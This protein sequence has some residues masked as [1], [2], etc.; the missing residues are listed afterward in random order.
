MRS[1]CGRDEDVLDTWFSSGLWPFSTLGWPEE[2]PELARFYPT[3]VL[4]T[5][6]DII[7][8]WVARMMMLG[9]HLMGEVPFRTSTSTASSATSEGKNVQDQGQHDRPARADRRVRC[10]RAALRAA[11]L[12]RAGRDIK[13]GPSRVEGYRNF[14][15]KLWNAARFA[16]LNDCR[17]DP[18]FD[19]RAAGTRSTAGSSARR[20]DGAQ[21][22]PRRWRPI[23]STMPRSAL[24]HFLWDKFCD[25]YVEL[26]KPL[27]TGEDA[28]AQAETRAT[29]AWALAQALHLLHPLA[30][31]V[32]EELWRELFG[33]PGGML[34][35]SPWPQLDQN[36]VD[37]VAEAELGWL[38]RLV[39]AI[40]A[41]RTELNVPPGAR[42]ALHQQ[43]ARS[44]PGLARAAS[45]SDPAAGAASSAIELEDRLAPP[46]A[47]GGRDRRGHV[48]AAGRRGHRSRR[49]AGE[50]RARGRQAHRRD[51]PRP[52]RSS[53]TRRS[54]RAHPKRWWSSSASGW[55]RAE[56][57]R[58]RLH[59]A[60]HRIG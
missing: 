50:A 26:A 46:K 54:W 53:P 39:G 7:F 37:P 6:F 14:G 12:D 13:F 48:R 31:F 41:A 22:S 24:Y 44:D 33:Q 40:R 42:L 43:G 19:P 20:R 57:T 28:A 16:E 49:R 51:R 1:R 47:L 59:Q 60:L 9:L 3:S 35:R 21:R 30:P 10:R 36:L 29:A 15:T 23:V 11:G 4:V 55:P 34:I 56:A 2:T 52:S 17:L 27:S 18:A 32:T 8:F 38:V 5:G 58:D 45:R 25:W